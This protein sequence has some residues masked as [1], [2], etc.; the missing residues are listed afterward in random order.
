MPTD[1][2]E[3]QVV[4][5]TEDIV[6]VLPLRLLGKINLVSQVTIDADET[7]KF[8]LLFQFFNLEWSIHNKIS[9]ILINLLEILIC[10]LDRKSVV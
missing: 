9:P 5:F 8:D 7:K 4:R 3:K 1:Y 6:K 2:L 10:K